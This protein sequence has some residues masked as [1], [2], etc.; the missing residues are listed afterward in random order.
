MKKQEWLEARANFAAVW[1]AELQFVGSFNPN[2]RA[3]SQELKNNS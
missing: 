1:A 3:G 2:K